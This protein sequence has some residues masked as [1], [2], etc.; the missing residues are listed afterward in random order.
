MTAQLKDSMDQMNEEITN[1]VMTVVSQVAPGTPVRSAESKTGSEYVEKGPEK[2]DK[3]LENDSVDSLHA[4]IGEMEKQISELSASESKLLQELTTTQSIYANKETILSDRVKELELLQSTVEEQL[5]CTDNEAKKEISELRNQLLDSR[6]LRS[7]IEN[8]ERNLD[9][10]LAVISILEGT[11]AK[12][13]SELQTSRDVKDTADA[14]NNR[15]LSHLEEE[16]VALQEQLSLS[17]EKLEKVLAEQEKDKSLH[18]RL[19]TS[20]AAYEG[21]ILDLQNELSTLRDTA[22]AASDESTKLRG[23]LSSIENNF[24]TISAE[25]EQ[26]KEKLNVADLSAEK[27]R[28]EVSSLRRDKDELLQK[29]EA[30]HMGPKEKEALENSLLDR[31]LLLKAETA[32][33]E[34]LKI[35]NEELGNNLSS[36]QSMNLEL[37]NTISELQEQLSVVQSAAESSVVLQMSVEDVTASLEAEKAKSVALEAKIVEIEGLLASEQ[38]DSKL[39]IEELTAEVIS[40]QHRS[41]ANLHLETTLSEVRKELENETIHGAEMKNRLEALRKELE[42][43]RDDINTA[44]LREK[45][46]RREMKQ[47]EKAVEARIVSLADEAAALKNENIRLDEELTRRVVDDASMRDANRLLEESNSRLSEEVIWMT[48]KMEDQAE[49]MQ[50]D[51]EEQAGRSEDVINSIR[52]ELDDS[53]TGESR[54]QEIIAAQKES[55]QSLNDK[56]DKFE[57]ETAMLRRQLKDLEDSAQDAHSLRL[58]LETA[59]D[60]LSKIEEK[61]KREFENLKKQNELISRLH[62]EKETAEREREKALAELSSTRTESEAEEEVFRKAIA[63]KDNIIAELEDKYS[64][65]LENAQSEAGIDGSA[66]DINA[67]CPL[68]DEL[69][70]DIARVKFEMEEAK[71]ECDQ[72]RSSSQLLEQDRDSKAIEIQKMVTARAEWIDKLSQAEK[73]LIRLR[74]CEKGLISKTEE[75]QLLEQEL[76]KSRALVKEKEIAAVEK[77]NQIFAFKDEIRELKYK[78]KKDVVI[79]S[80][81]VVF[82]RCLFLVYLIF[83]V[84]QSLTPSRSI[85]NIEKGLSQLGAT[86]RNSAKKNSVQPAGDD[87]STLDL[88]NGIEKSKDE[89]EGVS[90]WVLALWAWIRYCQ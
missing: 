31:E 59:K 26:M 50:K 46:L 11:N 48:K 67:G 52:I 70:I 77:E 14:D 36:I 12:L 2:A 69:K 16:K 19:A 58:E 9:G 25:S 49:R 18:E 20:E 86:S 84:L 82:F 87:I 34:E 71:A 17:N 41:D 8:L 85:D 53:R 64:F 83:S 88:V 7:K 39:R 5:A 89:L 44:E 42:Q 57:K 51:R 55:L 32:R 65:I 22:S 33:V 3:V 4:R 76:T 43:S 30:S 56:V 15:K 47:T 79:S 38:R 81:E 21:T 90:P 24:R 72:L 35:Q 73:E 29:Y 74:M 66:G 23:E 45:N 61:K 60:K 68:C 80:S 28:D 13:E 75:V 37:K 63:E 10:K 78:D 6:E 1:S 40:L 27:L 54:A 62:R